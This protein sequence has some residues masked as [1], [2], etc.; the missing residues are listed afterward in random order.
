MRAGE[1][2][3][4]GAPRRPLDKARRDFARDLGLVDRLAAQEALG[5]RGEARRADQRHLAIA[6]EIAHQRAGV[7]ARDRA[8]RRQHADQ[9]RSAR[10]RRPA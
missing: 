5:E 7:V 9:A 1:H 2:D 8:G 10:P 3:L 4:I 6:G